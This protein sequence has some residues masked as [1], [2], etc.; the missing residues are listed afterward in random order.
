M[1][2]LI[3][4]ILD[5]NGLTTCRKANSE[6]FSSSMCFKSC[7]YP[8]Y[9]ITPHDIKLKLILAG[10]SRPSNF[11]LPSC[12]GIIILLFFIFLYSGMLIN[13]LDLPSRMPLEKP[14]KWMLSGSAS[15]AAPMA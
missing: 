2:V 11:H 3:I 12:E 10:S 14:L 15:A 4:A 8:I 5:Q 13:D 1:R 9:T 7:L 6:N